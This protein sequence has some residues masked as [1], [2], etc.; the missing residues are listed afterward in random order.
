MILVLSEAQ[1]EKVRSLDPN[2]T[3]EPY[4]VSKATP[5]PHNLF[6]Y[7]REHFPDWTVDNYGPVYI[8]KAGQTVALSEANLAMFRRAIEVYEGNTVEVEN[9]V[10]R[11]NGEPATS[12]TFKMD[13]YWMMGDNRH[14]SEDARVWGF[15]PQD[16]IVGKPLFIWMS[17]KDGSMGK[18]IRWNRLFKSA[19]KD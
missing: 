18:G 4:D 17:A 10:I 12:Y 13:Y 1:K 14:N 9:G 16:H 19:S 5:N 6:P 8:P 3:I 11:I 2:V 15:V 7:D